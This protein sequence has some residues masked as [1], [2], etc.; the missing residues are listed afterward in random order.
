[1]KKLICTI[2]FGLVLT[3]GAQDFNVVKISQLPLFT[4]QV[5]TNALFVVAVPGVQTYSIY[6]APLANGIIGLY[7]NY[8]ALSNA[9]FSIPLT[10]AAIQDGYIFSPVTRNV[11]SN[12]YWEDFGKTNNQGQSLISAALSAT[13]DVVFYGITNVNRQFQK[14]SY[15][16]VSSASPY[17]RIW[18]PTNTVAHF[19]TNYGPWIFYPSNSWYVLYLTNGFAMRMATETNTYFERQWTVR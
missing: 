19:Q 11:G 13:N 8:F 3:V 7:S 17:A 16:I 10:G 4:G 12:T 14:L 9:L 1:M 2:F 6:A 5:P 15:S 18:I